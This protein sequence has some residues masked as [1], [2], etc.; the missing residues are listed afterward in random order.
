M[1]ASKCNYIVV[2]ESSPQVFSSASMETVLKTAPPKNCEN[3]KKTVL[4]ISHFP[5]EKNVKCYA[6]TDEELIQHEKDIDDKNAEREAKRKA[7]E[8]LSDATD[9]PE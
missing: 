1:A 3:D 5:D 2:Y 8:E 6:L 7:K 9:P 4:F